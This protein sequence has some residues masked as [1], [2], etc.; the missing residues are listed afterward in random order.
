MS[1]RDKG[2]EAA[3]GDP[4]RESIG[5]RRRRAKQA[6]A[7]A[8]LAGN[9]L[10]VGL[11]LAKQQHAVWLTS[12]QRVPIR[13]F[14]IAHSL[15]GLE[16]LLREAEHE[17]VAGG[18]DRLLVFME[19]TSHFWKTV[20]NFL[21]SRGIA[22]RTVSSLAVDRKREIEHITFAKGDYRDA[23]LIAD[24]G[25]NG[26]WLHRKLEREP[27]WIELRALAMEHE[28]VLAQHTRERV[29][30]RSLLELA[31]PEF[32]TCFENPL[33]KTARAL[34]RRLTRPLH[35]IPATHAELRARIAE[36]LDGSRLVHSKARALVARLELAPSFGVER[37]L[38]SSL[39][40]IGFA[41]ERFEVLDDEL[42][43]VRTRLLEIYASTPYHK[44]L[45]TIPAIGPES[46]ALV[47]AFVGDPHQ[48]DRASC[49]AKLAG[50]E[51]RENASGQAE[52]SHSI[53]RRGLARLRHVLYRIVL[54]LRLHNP[55]FAAY[56]HHLQSREKK[57]LTWFQAAVAAGNK[58]LRLFHR[59]CLE[60]KP[61]DP[62]K[63][64]PQA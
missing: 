45:D 14:M 55:E 43:H 16:K 7:E 64:I 28:L 51:P 5:F 61:Y 60:G 31:I 3:A 21:E 40:R 6:A 29:R 46:H 50:T 30:I 13:R 42:Q 23:E 34:L 25:T 57:P 1:A 17:R 38:A 49:L 33:A 4:G 11:D 35:Q 2:G 56:L 32:L 8:F 9:P 59:M 52:G 54:G 19:P 22:Y 62:S 41:L 37:L 58:Y 24:L 47:L 48:Y 15:E 12:R 53:S 18:F 63:L 26:H 27:L 36:R 20:A 10:I 44:V 39:A